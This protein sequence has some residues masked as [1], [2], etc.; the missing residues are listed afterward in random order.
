MPESGIVSDFETVT[1]SETGE[2]SLAIRKDIT[3]TAAVIYKK[4]FD[5]MKNIDL[6]GIT[7]LSELDVV[8]AMLE[9]HIQE[10]LDPETNILRF[11]ITAF[12]DY[13]QKE[14][15]YDNVN[16][17]WNKYL[18]KKPLSPHVN[19]IVDV[20]NGYMRYD[21]VNPVEKD[22][23]FM[24]MC[25]WN[26]ADGKHR[27][28]A[29]N[30]VWLLNGDYGWD[31]HVGTLFFVYD[32]KTRVMRYVD[33]DDIGALYDGD[34]LSVFFLPRK[35]KDIRVSAAGGGERWNEIL[36]W[37]GYRFSRQRIE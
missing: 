33:I 14:K 2:E 6:F 19:I 26:C 5:L 24:E 31:K 34:G 4:A 8:Q 10:C 35:G 23:T 36:I 1:D 37:D 12:L 3:L 11:G 25:F 17:E 30:T 32:N 15:F 18:K 9:E 22:T 21:I 20:K 29:A 27:L 7:T 16:R 28:I 13:N